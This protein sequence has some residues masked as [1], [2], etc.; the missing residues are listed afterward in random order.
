VSRYHHYE[1]A[2]GID[3]LPLNCGHQHPC[4]MR[5]EDCG[6]QHCPEC[7]HLSADGIMI[8][9][10]CAPKTVA[11]LNGEIEVLTAHRDS[12]QK[13]YCAEFVKVPTM[14]VAQ[15]IIRHA[16]GL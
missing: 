15:A 3:A 12:L 8:C 14:A 6:H 11:F 10:R 9:K 13:W 16:E 5:C 1:P 2:D 4:A 7:T